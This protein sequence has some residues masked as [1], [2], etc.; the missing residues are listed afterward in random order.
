VIKGKILMNIK[1]KKKYII[2]LILF[3]LI[4]LNITISKYLSYTADAQIISTQNEIQTLITNNSDEFEEFSSLLLSEYTNIIN[5]EKEELD[6]SIIPLPYLLKYN[7]RLKELAYLLNCYDG[8]VLY[9]ENLNILCEIIYP[10]QIEY[11]DFF[12]FPIYKS[13]TKFNIHIVLEENDKPYIVDDRYYS[14]NSPN[15]Y[16]YNFYVAEF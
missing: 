2:G 7:E 15:I 14:T 4:A 3:V 12:I 9:D 1:K 8:T 6:S 11:Y 10:K 13:S 16:I 5:T